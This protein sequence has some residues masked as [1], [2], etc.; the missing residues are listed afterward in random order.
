MVILPLPRVLERVSDGYFILIQVL[1]GGDFVLPG[2][3]WAFSA[4]WVFLIV[5][6]GMSGSPVSSTQ[7]CL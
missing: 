1:S 4:V 6:A 2:P 3:R 7:G 5:S